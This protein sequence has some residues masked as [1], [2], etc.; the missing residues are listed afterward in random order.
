MDYTLY[1]TIDAMLTPDTLSR[2]VGQPITRVERRAMHAQYAKSGSHLLA[3]ET[4]Q[5]TGP[6]FI[7]KRVARAWDWQMRATDD[8]QCRSVTLWTGGLFDRMP[9]EIEHG[10][11]ACARD[12]EGWAILMRDLGAALLPYAPL[13][14]ADHE[15]ILDALASLHATFFEA[16]DLRDPAL[17]I[18]TLQH[19]Y[20][21]FSPA[22]GH[23]EAAGTDEIPKRILEGWDLL[24]QL[25]D[26]DIAGVLRRL[27]Q[28]PAPLCA[29]LARYPATLVHG[30]ARHANMGLIRD[31]QP[32]LVMLDWALAAVAPPAV[33]L[34]RYLGTNTALLPV[35]KEHTLGF[36]RQ[37]LAARLGSRF[38]HDWWLPQLEL[39]LLGGFVQ[40]GW[41]MALKSTGWRVPAIQI[42]HWQADLRWWSAQVRTGL[43]WL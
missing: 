22:T 21:M 16:A 8:D 37:R 25:V 13:S 5:G 4:N 35:S 26:A 9:A 20:T 6:R 14:L 23:R 11:V 10:T 18:G 43:K 31:G 28:D 33:E 40:D 41:A 24:L 30:D 32:R 3:V 12:G 29:A 2:L 39:G 17:G 36:Y 34:G 42:P 27:S 1:P 38:S 15:C 7:L 19:V